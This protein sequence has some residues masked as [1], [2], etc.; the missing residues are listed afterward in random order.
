MMNPSTADDNTDDPTI[1]RCKDFARR[2]GYAILDVV[3]LFA[4]R[5]T[6]PIEIDYAHDPVGP[7][8]DHH[9][10]EAVRE[11]DDVIVAWGAMGA[12]YDRVEEVLRLLNGHPIKCLGVTKD[13]HPRHPLYLRNDAELIPYEYEVLKW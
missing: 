5:A 7:E 1:R 12:K 10:M 9:I 6:E 2:F 4:F 3:N 11:S 13:G 8:T